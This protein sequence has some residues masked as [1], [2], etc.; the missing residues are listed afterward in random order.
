MGLLVKGQWQDRWYDTD[1]TGGRFERSEAVFR[2]W[3]TVD[4]KAGLRGDGGFK[5][6]AGRYHLYASYACPW[7]HRVLIYRA[8]KGLE[9]MIDVS[10]VH[11]FMG[12]KGWTFQSDDAGLVG[13]KLSGKDYLYEVYQQAD[14]DFTGRVTVPILWD[15]RQNTIVSNESS[16]IIR[17]LN[18]AFDNI[19]ATPGD[20]YP[21]VHRNAIDSINDRVY[22]TLNNGVYKCGFA[23]TQAAYDEAIVPLFDTLEWLELQLAEQRFL[24]G[25][26]PLEAD[27]RLLP[28]LLRFD[29][30]YNG[31]FKCNLKRLVDYPNLWAYTRDLY[32]WPGIRTTCN[33]WHAKHHYLESH[34]TVNPHRI[35]PIGPAIDFDEPHGREQLTTGA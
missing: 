10:F 26:H 35:V 5:A 31:H 22:N 14:P 1:A 11:W 12:D 6:E 17:M 30:V 23:T 21:D 32:Q 7:V 29:M 33:F 27:W 19:G 8:L 28:T 20:Y 25:D 18:S 4:G 2:H 13:D 9:S 3:I 15:K 16:E 24:C 34:E